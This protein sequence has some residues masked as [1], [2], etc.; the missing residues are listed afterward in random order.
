MLFDFIVLRM[1]IDDVFNG[2]EIIKWIWLKEKSGEMILQTE[3]K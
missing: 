3:K 2:E 1:K